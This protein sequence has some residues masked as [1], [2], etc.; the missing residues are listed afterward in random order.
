MTIHSS[1]LPKP[2]ANHRRR[3]FTLIEVLVV[4][5]I[6]IL[7]VVM[8]LPAFRFITGSRSSEAA[9]NQIAAALSVAR[10]QAIGVQDTRGVAIYRDPSN[11]RS[12][13]AIIELKNSFTQFVSGTGATY[14]RGQYVYTGTGPYQAYVCKETYVSNGPLNDPIT[15][16]NDYW[17]PMPDMNTQVLLGNNFVDITP[18]SEF[19]TLPAGVSVRGVANQ[20]KFPNN[21]TVSPDPRYRYLN[22]AVILFDSNGQLLSTPYLI[23]RTGLLGKV[24]GDQAGRPEG[25]FPLP[26]IAN[27]PYGLLSNPVGAIATTSQI[28]LVVFDSETLGNNVPAGV[29]NTSTTPSDSDVSKVNDYLDQNATPI[30]INRYNGTLVK[31]D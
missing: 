2:L 6:I 25:F 14:T 27:F 12:I 26:R 31:G 29:L 18:N 15:A 30:M 13:V 1:I 3:A 5:G 22:P 8:A 10:A 20:F 9:T 28:G 17:Q 23:S 24:I 21:A 19:L 7:L 11:D 4:M 16:G